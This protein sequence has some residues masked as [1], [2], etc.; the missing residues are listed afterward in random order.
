MNQITTLV[1]NPNHNGLPSQEVQGEV[2]RRTKNLIEVKFFHPYHPA[3]EMTGTF[4]L[5]T[6]K[7]I[8]TDVYTSKEWYLKR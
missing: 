7:M 8:R 2:T 1:F 6:G 3:I 4:N 5:N